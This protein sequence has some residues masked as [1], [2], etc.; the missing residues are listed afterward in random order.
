MLSMVEAT[1]FDVSWKD[2][3]SVEDGCE[4]RAIY[5]DCLHD[6]DFVVTCET[7]IGSAIAVLPANLTRFRIS[8]SSSRVAVFG[9]ND[10]WLLYRSPWNPAGIR[11][12]HDQASN[13]LGLALAVIQ[14][15]IDVALL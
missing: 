1:V 2:N 5:E 8:A 3:S 9:M 11:P 7:Y 10:G 13:F 4:I 12:D 15:E 14:S 6:M